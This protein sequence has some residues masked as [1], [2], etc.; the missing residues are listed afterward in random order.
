[1]SSTA[2]RVTLQPNRIVVIGECMLELTDDGS[3]Q[4]SLSYAGDVLNTAV[5]LA[6]LGFTSSFIT[7]IGVDPYSNMMIKSWAERGIDTSHV[8]R[9]PERIPG[10]YAVQRS[11][12]GDRD[13]HYWRDQSAARAICSIPGWERCAEYACGAS[14]F[15][16]TGISLAIL[17]AESRY[18][19]L[20]IAETVGKRGGF[21]IFDPNFRRKLWPDIEDARSWMERAAR[22]ANMV[23]PTD[24]D[25]HELWSDATHSNSTKKWFEYGAQHVV[26]KCGEKGASWETPGGY[27]IT[28]PAGHPRC[29][30][31]TTGAGDAF[32]AGLIAG[33]LENRTPQETLCYAN[34]VAAET[35][36]YHG[37]LPK[38][39]DA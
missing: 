36:S 39:P 33:L 16:F 18:Q 9:H 7:A 38:G 13:F 15:Y 1:M 6:R 14:V 10:L 12:N 2:T 25:D 30:V 34:Q 3:G 21:V 4:V 27:F 8:L 19:I 20:A 5:H 23:V 24:A 32:N 26:L 35:L 29:I 11:P 31:D 28:S 37:A 22:Y 17:T